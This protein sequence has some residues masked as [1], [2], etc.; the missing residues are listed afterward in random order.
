MSLI[1]YLG[2]DTSGSSGTLSPTA[3]SVQQTIARVTS[4]TGKSG[5]SGASGASGTS[6]V[7]I[8]IQARRAAAEKADAGKDGAALAGEMR[9]GLD[10]AYGA[11]GRKDTADLTALSGRAL[12]IIALGEGNGFSKTEAAAAK[13]ELRA[14]DRQSL[15]QHM[16]ATPLTAASLTAFQNERLAAQALMSA[17]EQQLR[18]ASPALR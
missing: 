5:A 8:T 15:I 14:R 12:A 7:L 18:E 1:A 17:E 2:T 16:T 11:A 3:L 4:G 13:L 9:K 10:E 6:Q